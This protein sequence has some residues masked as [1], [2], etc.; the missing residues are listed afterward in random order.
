MIKRH[1]LLIVAVILASHLVYAQ[2]YVETRTSAGE[3]PNPVSYFDGVF[4]VSA[5]ATEAYTGNPISDAIVTCTMTTSGSVPTTF[6]L[7]AVDNNGNYGGLFTPSNYSPG[8]YSVVCAATGGS[9]NYSDVAGLDQSVTFTIT[10]NGCNATDASW[11]DSSASQ[12]YQWIT[13]ALYADLSPNPPSQ[14]PPTL[15]TGWGTIDD[16]GYKDCDADVI[17]ITPMPPTK[18]AMGFIPYLNGGITYA[19]NITDMRPVPGTACTSGYCNGY[20]DNTVSETTWFNGTF[21]YPG[22]GQ[23]YCY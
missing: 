9:R 3:T 12:P 20:E 21:H 17:Y 19:W 15:E 18:Q 2:M 11:E 10:G 16:S 23:A 6:R 1:V 14:P 22:S 13:W 5:Y 8:T 7:D 4:T